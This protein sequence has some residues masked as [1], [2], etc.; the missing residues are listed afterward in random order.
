MKRIFDD[1]VNPSKAADFQAKA[2]EQKI[3]M[4]SKGAD[5]DDSV[6]GG[7]KAKGTAKTSGQGVSAKKKSSDAYLDIIILQQLNDDIVELERLGNDLND[8]DKRMAQC[9][10]DL[11]FITQELHDVDDL[12]DTSGNYK[13]CLLYTSPSPRDRG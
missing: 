4:A 3:L 2:L 5:G 12:K 9:Q 6:A 7:Y 10:A 11:D 1:A 13:P 8:I